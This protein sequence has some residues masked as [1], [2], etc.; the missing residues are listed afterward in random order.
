MF[1]VYRDGHPTNRLFLS[2]ENA[3]LYI[4]RMTDGAE[5][6]IMPYSPW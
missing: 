6:T 1:E 3:K 5:Y 2:E 4:G